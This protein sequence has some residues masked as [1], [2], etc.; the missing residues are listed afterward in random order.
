MRVEAPIDRFPTERAR[1]PAK[2]LSS[3]DVT[4][5]QKQIDVQS[6]EYRTIDEKIQGANW[7]TELL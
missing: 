2:I 5:L 4:K 3:V 6:K 1:R 7:T